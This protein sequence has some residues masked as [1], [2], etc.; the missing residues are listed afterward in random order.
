[1]FIAV[2]AAF[3]YVAPKGSSS[4]SDTSFK[5]TVAQVRLPH[6]L[7]LNWKYYYFNICAPSVGKGGATRRVRNVATRQAVT[8]KNRNNVFIWG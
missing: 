6:A 8:K 2:Y 3:G 1:M 7:I 5:F 4:G